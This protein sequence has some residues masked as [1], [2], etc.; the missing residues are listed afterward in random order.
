MFFAYELMNN[1]CIFPIY[2]H[3]DS[4]DKYVSLKR[5]FVSQWMD[6]GQVRNLYPHLISE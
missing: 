6:T 3:G 1:I 4:I 5:L 2:E